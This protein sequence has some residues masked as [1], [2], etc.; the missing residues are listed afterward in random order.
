MAFFI[1]KTVRCVILAI[2]LYSGTQYFL[3]WKSYTFSPKVFREKSIAAAQPANGLSNVNKLRN[4]LSREYRDHIL[5][6]TWEAVYGGGLLLRANFLHASLTEFIVAFHAA[7]RTQ[8]F[9]GFHWINSTCTVLN[10]AVSRT[11]HS[12]HGGNKETFKPGNNFRHGEFQRYFYEFSDDTYM[13]CYG[14]GAVPLS[15]LWLATGSISAADPLSLVRIFYI[16]GHGSIH[17]IG[18]SLKKTFNYYK[19]RVV[20]SEL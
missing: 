9:S 17:E 15:S 8:G 7:H 1:T 16:Y 13:V 14:R 6:P 3:R 11:L 19:S 5:D 10:G 20:K 2:L 4:D 18:F 12:L